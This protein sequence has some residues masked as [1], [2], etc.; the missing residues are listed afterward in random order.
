MADVDG[1]GNPV[2]DWDRLPK[3]KATIFVAVKK[4]SKDIKKESKSTR[5]ESK[6]T[7]KESK[8]IEKESED[9][10]Q[11]IFTAQVCF[12]QLGKIGAEEDLFWCF[13]WEDGEK[14]EETQEKV[15]KKGEEG[16]KRKEKAT[17]KQQEM[18]EMKEEEKGKTKEEEKK[19]WMLSEDLD[20]LN[21]Y[22]LHNQFI[23]S[24]IF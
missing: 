4:E 13:E 19:E 15:K 18:K 11:E 20:E 8:Y 3:K 23:A 7:K 1:G 6:G 21:I 14:D 10:K 9:K 22:F 17:E 12:G 2:S 16:K 24:T 5:K